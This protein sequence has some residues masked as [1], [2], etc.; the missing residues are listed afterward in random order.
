MLWCAAGKEPKTF[1]VR[2]GFSAFFPRAQLTT[3]SGFIRR[4][5]G[6][7][8]LAAE[9]ELP[10]GL[11]AAAGAAAGGSCRSS[12][13]SAY[14]ASITDGAARQDVSGDLLALL[15]KP[16]STSDLTIVAIAGSD[17][18][19]DTGGSGNGEAPAATWLKRKLVTDKGR[20]GG[21]VG[22]PDT[23]R[24]FDVHR[25]ILAA[26]CPYFATHFASGMGDSAA[27]ELDMPDTDPGALAAL[28]RFIYGGELVVAS[29]AQARAGLALADRLLLPKAVA[30]L[31][32]QLL[33][34]L[35]PSAIAA[36]LMWAAGCGDQAGLLV[37]LLD[38]AAEA[39]DEVPQSD[40]QQLAAAHPGL[41]A[42]L[43]AASVRA[44][45]RSKS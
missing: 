16:G 28:L 26:R 41:T 20:K 15:E 12:S 44:A 22:S 1:N 27:R 2:W 13:S 42:Q 7:L 38:F 8:L 10:A 40:L 25:A 29:R 32:A 30:L 23:R 18:G 17:S 6:A 5:D 4:R 45:K 35:C 3:D 11:A 43:F 19:A 39:A 34:S 31:R 36:D 21:C 14:P 24:R 37:E 9:I 33:A